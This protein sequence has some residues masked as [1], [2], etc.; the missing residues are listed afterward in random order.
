V[1]LVEA[2]AMKLLAV[3]LVLLLAPTAFAG[4]VIVVD[5]SGGGDYT[6][7][8][9]AAHAAADGD[10]LLVKQGQ[11]GSLNVLGKG[12][13]VTAEVGHGVTIHGGIVI[14]STGSDQPTHLTGLG[15]LGSHAPTALTEY[16]AIFNGCAG[17]VRIEGC[18]LQGTKGGWFTGDKDYG[19]PG[20]W[21]TNCADVTFTDCK[22][23]GG[24]SGTTWSCGSGLENRAGHGM[25]VDQGSLVSLFQCKVA[26]G[27]AYEYDICDIECGGQQGHGAWALDSRLY[28]AGTKLRGGQGGSEGLCGVHFPGG[29]GLRV[30]G[31]TA[32]ADVL[33]MTLVGGPG[34]WCGGP[35]GKR[36]ALVGGG[37][38]TMLPG[39]ARSMAGTSPVRVGAKLRLRFVGPPN[40][41]VLLTVS[42]YPSWQDQV[43]LLSAPW[44]GTG[45]S[46][47]AFLGQMPATGKVTH[48]WPVTPIQGGLD[49]EVRYLQA[50]FLDNSQGWL[51][52]PNTVV[53]LDPSF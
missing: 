8:Q 11:Y 44:L 31:A 4:D 45:P 23:D 40:E 15:S 17:A 10:T 25:V 22:I 18:V 37:S 26:A 51:G 3:H 16:G 13:T 35:P 1:I 27:N 50:F 49:S 38:A 24:N 9:S 43:P 5:A 14:R 36:L 41:R 21:I 30:E 20:A 28:G 32:H 33:D 6:D 2:G 39:V 53:V 19:A 52:S 29:D 42:L 48:N 12:L 46:W 34:N 47:V 7:L